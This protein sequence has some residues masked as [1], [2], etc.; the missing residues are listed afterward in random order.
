MHVP[1]ICLTVFCHWLT[2]ER[3]IFP[4]LAAKLPLPS[5]KTK[6]SPQP[7]KVPERRR[8]LTNLTRFKPHLL[9]SERKW[10]LTYEYHETDRSKVLEHFPGLS[11]ALLDELPLNYIAPTL[12][13]I[14]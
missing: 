2:A 11:S 13:T 9:R 14:E 8:S 5:L 4:S 10:A 1:R 12:K 3:N 7:R 6:T